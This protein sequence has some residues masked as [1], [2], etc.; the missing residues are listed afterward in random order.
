[1]RSQIFISYAHKDEWYLELFE[2]RLQ[3]KYDLWTDRNIRLGQGW[4]ESIDEAIRKSFA[5]LVILTPNSCESKYVTYEWSYALGLGRRV[6]T[7]V[8]EVSEKVHPRLANLQ[9]VEFLE[10]VSDRWDWDRLIDALKEE[11]LV[12]R[13][14]EGVGIAMSLLND[15]IAKIQKK[16][17]HNALHTLEEAIQFAP[18][19]QLDDIHYQI[20]LAYKALDKFD[21]VKEHLNKVIR[22]NEEHA[23]AMAMLG[24]LYRREAVAVENDN[25]DE[26]K[27]LLEKA[28]VQFDDALALQP[29][30]LDDNNESVYALLGGI[31]KRME[32]IDEAITAYHE[33]TKYRGTSYPYNNLGLL[34][35]QQ[36][37]ADKMRA[38]FRLVH[39]LATNKIQQQDTI[40]AWAF[41]DLLVAQ[42]VLREVDQAEDTLETILA[43]PPSYALQR[44]LETLEDDMQDLPG[45]TPEVQAFIDK[46]VPMLRERLK[47]N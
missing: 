9:W 14:S 46:A 10:R 11:E 40:D 20:A 45:A 5:V 34:Y 47:A 3:D 42:I 24:D 1:M 37:Q 6:I 21:K 31:L 27:H 41:N 7:V 26:Y 43:I 39:H 25:P 8:P 22:Y 44:L 16:D 38:T 19:H 15:G 35:I 4:K 13:A 23:Q 32:H 28:K 29:H 30:V 36:K 2:K 17:Y 33:A 18:Q 12:F